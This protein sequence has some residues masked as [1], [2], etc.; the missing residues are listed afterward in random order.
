MQEHFAKLG[1][2]PIIQPIFFRNFKIKRG[3][4]DM[5]TYALSGGLAVYRSQN[6]D[7]VTS[8]DNTNVTFEVV[9]PDSTTTFS[10]TALPLAP[11]DEPGDEVVDISLIPDTMRLNGQTVQSTSFEYSIFEVTWTYGGGVHTSTVFI[12][13]REDSGEDVDYIFVISGDPLPAINTPADW[14]ALEASITAISVPTGTYGPGVN[15]PLTSLGGT[16]SEHDV[17]VGTSNADEFR[18]GD[19]ND[20]INGLGGSDTL[21]GDSGN[22]TLKGGSGSDRLDG[23]SG[24]DHLKGGGNNDRLNGGGGKDKLEGEGGRD[25]LIGG[26]GNDRL[27]GGGGND[28][29][30][31]GSGR[32]RLIG[33]SGR[34]KLD[35]DG[36]N[37]RMTGG[38]GND[39]FIFSR[40]NDVVTDFN[41]ASSGERVDLRG[42][43]GITD[44]SDLM[45][46]HVTRVNG[47]V[48]IDDLDG[49]T[50]TLN[51][52]TLSSLGA[53]DFIF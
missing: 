47:N 21:R 3:I 48:I 19:G 18:G 10:Y 23:G 53:D 24:R 42:V 17:I 26:G 46:N 11:G 45:D 40:G 14:N 36:G 27:E 34:D 38:G 5:T 29:L 7:T 16:V 51:S 44:F 4:F 30:D 50:L 49:N 20:I 33:G 28:R 39:T 52:T 35:G 2:P 31:G 41:A 6:P 32:D 1:E 25:R 15:I 8:V 9:V 22:D 13:F 37:D 12:P 43:T